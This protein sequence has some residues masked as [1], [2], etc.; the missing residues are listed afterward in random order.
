MLALLLVVS[1]L[2]TTEAGYCGPQTISRW[3]V[4]VAIVFGFPV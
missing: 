2:V 3:G 4:A 1:Y